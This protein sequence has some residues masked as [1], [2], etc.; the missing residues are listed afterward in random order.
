MKKFIKQ[1]IPPIILSILNNYF[2]SSHKNSFDCES[3]NQSALI[4][5]SFQEAYNSCSDK[6][7]ENEELVNSVIKKNRDY[8]TYLNT[9]PSLSL[10]D[11]SALIPLA[12]ASI[13]DHKSSLN[14]IDFGGGGGSHFTAI[15]AAIKA[16]NLKWAVVETYAMTIA[17]KCLENQNLKFYDSIT[18]AKNELGNVDLIFSSGS[19]QYC[20]DPLTTLKSIINIRAKFLYFC[21][22]P[23]I[24]SDKNIITIQTSLL[25]S[26]GPGSLSGEIEDRLLSYP[27]TFLSRSKFEEVLT[28]RYK[29]IFKLLEKDGEFNLGKIK[30]P[31][32]GYFCVLNE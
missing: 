31:Q 30:V 17:A 9:I 5:S 3:I 1:C 15:K 16:T 8:V 25:S 26:N 27:I 32:S 10:Q 7:Y 11:L 24:D 29:I 20:S 2:K 12:I 4:Y 28:E 18:N 19:L 23:V 14:V 13:D 21:R 22:L 6:S